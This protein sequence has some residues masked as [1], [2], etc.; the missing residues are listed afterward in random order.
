MFNRQALARHWQTAKRVI[1]DS[2]HTAVRVGQ[3]LD[4]SVRVGR[5]LLGAVSPILDQL[6]GGHHM[7]PLVQGLGVYDQAR[8]DV[9][10]GVNNVQTHLSRIR[11]QVPELDL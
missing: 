4:H 3:G 5:K 9:M 11:R 7:K 8:G 6:G 10:H 2:W 1:G